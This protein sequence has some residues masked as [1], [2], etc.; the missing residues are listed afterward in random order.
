MKGAVIVYMT[1]CWFRPFQSGLSTFPVHLCSLCLGVGLSLL[2][3]HVPVIERAQNILKALYLLSQLVVTLFKT[4]QNMLN[5]RF[6]LF[7]SS[8]YPDSRYSL[9][10]LGPPHSFDSLDCSY[11]LAPCLLEHHSLY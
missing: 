11:S 3:R 9:H 4:I 7:N 8:A 1:P 10:S 2:Q 5:H 6:S